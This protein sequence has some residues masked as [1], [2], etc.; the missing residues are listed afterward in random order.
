MHHR[1][2]PLIGSAW[3]LTA[4]STELS[5]TT[6]NWD[7]SFG[8][9]ARST[10][11]LQIAQPQ[12]T[13]KDPVAGMDGNRAQATYERYQKPGNGPAAAAPAG[14]LDGAGTNK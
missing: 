14:M 6:P 4:C 8:T 1:L 12:G 9:R 3:L 2:L 10:L 7:Q 13:S 5:T 11:A